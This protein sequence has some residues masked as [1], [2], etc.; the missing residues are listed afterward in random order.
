LRAAKIIK[1]PEASS[2]ANF[3]M[4]SKGQTWQVDPAVP[5]SLFFSCPSSRQSTSQGP[6]RRQRPW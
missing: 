3:L 5:S 4:L 1:L 2:A 6:L